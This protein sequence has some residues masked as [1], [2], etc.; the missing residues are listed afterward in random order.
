MDTFQTF[1][2]FTWYSSFKGWNIH[3]CHG[4][5]DVT[6]RH[7]FSWYSSNNWLKHMLIDF[8]IGLY[9]SFQEKGPSDEDV[10]F[11]WDIMVLCSCWDILWK[12][13][14]NGAIFSALK[15]SQFCHFSYVQHIVIINILL[16]MSCCRKHFMWIVE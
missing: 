5:G 15:L 11:E 10:Y 1:Q 7:L 6:K 13:E 3:L 8:F 16:D 12:A 9:G 2:K 4:N 14:N